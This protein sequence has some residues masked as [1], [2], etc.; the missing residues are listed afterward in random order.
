MPFSTRNTA[1][2][3]TTN[4]NRA[5]PYQLVRLLIAALAFGLFASAC[6]A[7][8][9][10]QAAAANPQLEI[11]QAELE[12]QKAEIE[13]LRLEQEVGATEGDALAIGAPV[14]KTTT[15]TKAPEPEPEPEPKPEP[16]PTT[17]TTEPPKPTFR[18]QLVVDKIKII[19]DCDGIEGDGDFRMNASATL[20]AG[21]HVETFNYPNTWH[22]LGDGAE[23]S[24]SGIG[25]LEMVSEERPSIQVEFN[26]LER[27]TD[28]FGAV[29]DDDRMIGGDGS[30]AASYQNVTES[31]AEEISTGSGSCRAEL[32]FRVETQEVV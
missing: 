26:S 28:I 9:I 13:R 16:K 20:K 7:D 22:T 8:A 19:K 14:E 6:G 1:H 30:A 2:R 5:K 15:T 32:Y 27:D 29:W 25:T 3:D 31:F 12:L 23:V 11:L 24:L 10:D 21:D 18:T 17:T 4:R